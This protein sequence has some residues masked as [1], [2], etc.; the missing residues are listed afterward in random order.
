MLL[1]TSLVDSYAQPEW[2]IDKEQLK[3]RFPPHVRAMELWRVDPEYL[4]EMFG[5]ATR[6]A[7]RDQYEAGLGIITDGEM[8]RPSYATYIKHRL[9]GFGGEAGQYEFANLEEFPGAK[10]QV[11]G[12]KGRAKRSAPACT[13]PIKVIDMEAPRKDAERLTG[14]ADGHATFISAASPGVTALFFP[15][16]YYASDKEYVFAI[17][18]GCATIL[19]PLL[20]P[21]SNGFSVHAG[22][23]SLDPEIVWAKLAA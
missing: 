12:D 8:S 17:A 23:N 3:G 11:F 6:L 5:D 4:E 14:L 21:G 19:K 10:V 22:S 1:P 2:L 7:I 13:A 15:N 9:S 18:E 20:R 16:Q